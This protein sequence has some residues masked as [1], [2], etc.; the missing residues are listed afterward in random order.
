MKKFNPISLMLAVFAALMFTL[1]SCDKVAIETEQE[2]IRANEALK[3]AKSSLCDISFAK[4]LQHKIVLVNDYGVRKTFNIPASKLEF[5]ANQIGVPLT[6]TKKMRKSNF[7]K[8]GIVSYVVK[9][10]RVARKEISVVGNAIATNSNMQISKEKV[11]KAGSKIFY[12]VNVKPQFK[13]KLQFIELVYT[14]NNAK[15]KL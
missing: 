1:G 2:A 6:I 14:V 12:K 11:I 13:K 9:S 5:H 4:G 3:A 7:F 10:D 8:S 15:C